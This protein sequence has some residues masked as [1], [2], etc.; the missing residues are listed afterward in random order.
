MSVC[1]RSGMVGEQ[2]SLAAS[3]SSPGRSRGHATKRRAVGGEGLANCALDHGFL[4]C[5]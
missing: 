3:P 4:E 5:Q 2:T 1:Y